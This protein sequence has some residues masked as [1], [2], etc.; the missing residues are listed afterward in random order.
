MRS[1]QL[2]RITK[3]ACDGPFGSAIKS[4]HYEDGGARVIRLGNIGS[5]EWQGEDAAFIGLEYFEALRR[6]EVR[7]GDLLIAGLGD[8][9]NP[10]GRACAAPQGIGPGI[11]KADCYRFRLSE[12]DPRFFAY[13]LSSSAGIAQSAQLA[14]GSTRKR[15][16]LGKALGLR[17]PDLAV[18]QQRAIADYLDA[19]TAR[20][21]ALIAKKQQ[22]IHLLE[23]RLGVAMTEIAIPGVDPKRDFRVPSD[24][25]G[26]VTPRGWRQMPIG[27]LLARITYGFTNPMPTTDEGPFML[28]AN[29]V[30]DDGSVRYGTARRT[31][32]EAFAELTDKSRPKR[33]D[34]L[35]TKDGSLGRVAVMDGTR[36][37]V[38]QSVAVLTPR[39]GAVSGRLLA[40]LLR[41][42]AYRDAL[43][44]EAGGT[45]I[46]HLYITRVVKQ[47]LALPP[48]S[49]HAD[50]LRQLTT[51]EDEHRALAG[52]V[53]TQIDLLQEHRQTLITAAVTGEFTVPSAA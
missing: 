39:P 18:E 3:S 50:L 35:L 4:D 6:H 2:R 53:A 16:T 20:I 46:K 45:T 14:D 21:D 17:V 23:E 25:P 40:S 7:P 29:D 48:A 9:R 8:D 19:E 47:R 51:I 15:L 34:V 22:L 38:N 36:A 43:I 26:D 27:A 1:V 28:T 12:G 30:G 44:F 10:V 49:G 42:P 31:S 37:C 11:V 52:T 32:E 24:A 5:A 33:G 41:V 13:F